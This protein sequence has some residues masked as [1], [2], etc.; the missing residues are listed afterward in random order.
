[1][2][3]LKNYSLDFEQIKIWIFH[4]KIKHVTGVIG[5]SGWP[6]HHL[7]IARL[8]I[9]P[10]NFVCCIPNAVSQTKWTPKEWNNTRRI[11]NDEW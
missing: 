6:K 7:K 4:I 1:M 9:P 10:K 5:D 2:N 11:L 3:R 8:H